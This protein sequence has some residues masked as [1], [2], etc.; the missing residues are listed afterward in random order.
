MPAAEVPDSRRAFFAWRWSV[1]QR[2][3]TDPSI[4]DNPLVREAW[5]VAWRRGMTDKIVLQA[6]FIS[7]VDVF[8][9]FADLLEDLAREREA[10]QLIGDEVEA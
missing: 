7:A 3:S 8:R 5:S 1:L 2:E 10:V 9:R 6:E 4:V